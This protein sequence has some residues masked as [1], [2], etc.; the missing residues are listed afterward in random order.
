MQ[1]YKEGETMFGPRG[2]PIEAG[3][4][5]MGLVF[6][7]TYGGGDDGFMTYYDN[8][9]TVLGELGRTDAKVGDLS[10][11]NLWVS[12]LCSGLKFSRSEFADV[13]N[14]QAS[15]TTL[16]GERRVLSFLVLWV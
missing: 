5:S 12:N 3:V 2:V 7:G 10:L 9:S 11:P 16:P 13:T 15:P 4:C 1:T 6:N 14:R 8:N